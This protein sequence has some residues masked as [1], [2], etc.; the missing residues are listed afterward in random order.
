M[1]FLQ[2]FH[3]EAARHLRRGATT[4]F[5]SSAWAMRSAMSSR[6]GAAMICT[7][8]GSGSSG[9][10]TATTG[11]PMKEIGWVKMPRLARTGSSA[12]PNMNV[13]W[14][15]SG[16]VHGVAGATM[17]STSSNSLSTSPRYQRRNFC[18]FTTSDAGTMAPAI[19]RSRTA[20]SKSRARVRK[21]ARC[22]LRAFARGDDESRGACAL[23]LRNLDLAIGAER[24][25]NAGDGVDHLGDAAF[26]I[27]AGDRDAQVLDAPVQKRDHRLRRPLGT[28]R[29]VGVVALHGIISER[30]V[31]RRA[32]PAVRYDRGSQRTEKFPRGLSVRRWA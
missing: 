5:I 2:R 30:Q 14:P 28:H 22:K 21:R 24:R 20:G 29:I 31:A 13:C 18:A 19:S 8:I 11:R 32:A 9:T 16:A 15:I 17:A 12:S 1:F 4:P 25:G 6:Q 27:S 7:P 23:R 26:E 3:C 10:G